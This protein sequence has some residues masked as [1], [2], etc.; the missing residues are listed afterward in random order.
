MLQFRTG[1]A[2]IHGHLSLAAEGIPEEA[3]QAWR[4]PAGAEDIWEPVKDYAVDAGSD[5]VMVFADSFGTYA[6]GASR[7]HWSVFMPLSLRWVASRRL[8]N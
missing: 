2:T 6:P 1:D 7:E 5:G 8:T 4:R 3:I